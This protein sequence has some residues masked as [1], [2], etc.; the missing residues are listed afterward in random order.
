[1]GR[2][3]IVSKIMNH[4]KIH[5]RRFSVVSKIM[6]HKIKIH[7]SKVSLLCLKYEPFMTGGSLLCLNDEPKN[8]FS[9]IDIKILF[10]LIV[11]EGYHN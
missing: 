2:F 3:S 10:N 6:N 8:Y 11:L 7:N 5:N 4:K 9:K 1:M